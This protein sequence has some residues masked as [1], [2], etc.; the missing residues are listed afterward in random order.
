ML[1]EAL[2]KTELRDLVSQVAIT[3]SEGVCIG[4]D[5]VR[6]KDFW[7][8]LHVDRA[9]VVDPAKHGKI[10]T[11]LFRDIDQYEIRCLVMADFCERLW[12]L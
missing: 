1:N 2:F 4:S 5:Y 6:C 12:S 3:W 8:Q 9:V 11:Y 10:R 7:C